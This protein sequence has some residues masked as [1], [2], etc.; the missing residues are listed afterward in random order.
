MVVGLLGLGEDKGWTLGLLCL[1]P[2]CL[3]FICMIA[4]CWASSGLLAISDRLCSSPSVVFANKFCWRPSVSCYS[5]GGL[6]TPYFI[7]ISSFR[8]G[9]VLCSA[10]PD[11]KWLTRC[12]LNIRGVGIVH[13]CIQNMYNN[14]IF[15]K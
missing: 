1:C 8:L 7:S 3:P 9:S 5:L 4:L 6:C 15:F 2:L 10:D 11:S 14:N 12:M 13:K